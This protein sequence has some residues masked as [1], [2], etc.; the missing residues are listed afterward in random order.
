M[1]EQLDLEMTSGDESGGVRIIVTPPS[2]A[3]ESDEAR[4]AHQEEEKLETQEGYD[5]P[6]GLQE[7]SL[8]VCR[9]LKFYKDRLHGL[10]NDVKNAEITAM[11]AVAKYA[12]KIK[13]TQNDSMML[14]AK[15]QVGSCGFNYQKYR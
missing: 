15:I 2:P 13:S 4:R 5:G 9:T 8:H 3:R 1:D 10:N 11:N 14:E 12:H 7:Y 6:S